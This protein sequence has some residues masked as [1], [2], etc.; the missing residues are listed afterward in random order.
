MA[1]SEKGLNTIPNA[2]AQF[3]TN[4]TDNPLENDQSQQYEKLLDN[5]LWQ[6]ACQFYAQPGIE[7]ALLVLQDEYGADINLILHGLW[8]AEKEVEWQSSII[9]ARYSLWMKEQVLPLREMRREM[10]VQAINREWAGREQFRQQIKKVELIAE[11]H[12]LAMLYAASQPLKSKQ[13]ASSAGNY[14]ALNLDTL[15]E[16]F[17]IPETA[18]EPLLRLKL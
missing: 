16:Y 7:H 2:G 6:F 5:L 8:L 10:K 18:L 14:H 4:P 11:Q 13:S 12:A 1:D 3:A 15:T 9:P 17:G